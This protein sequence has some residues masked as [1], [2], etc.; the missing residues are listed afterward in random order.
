MKKFNLKFYSI[1]PFLLLSV[2]TGYS[3]VAQKLVQTK[4][5]IALDSI[6]L[7]GIWRSSWPM[8]VNI[9]NANGSLTGNRVVNTTGYTL[10]IGG[11]LQNFFYSSI[12]GNTGTINQ[13]GATIGIETN[14][15]AP[16]TA[17]S[18]FSASA[19]QFSHYG[20]SAKGGSTLIG[21]S[22]SVSPNN[23]VNYFLLDSNVVRMVADSLKFTAPANIG[24]VSILS[25][26]NVGIGTKVPVSALDV[27]MS[28][29]GDQLVGFFGNNNSSAYK[30]YLN[31]SAGDNTD[32]TSATFSLYNQ[33]N[34]MFSFQ[35][36]NNRTAIGASEGLKFDYLGNLTARGSLT[37]PKATLNIN[38]VVSSSALL[39][40]GTTFTGGTA[41][42][43]KPSL[44][45]EPAGASSTNWNTS[46][47]QVGINAASG[48]TG[49]I[50]WGGV[51]GSNVFKVD[52]TGKT[53][54]GNSSAYNVPNIYG[55]TAQSGLSIISDEVH[56]IS[57]S[58]GIWK[59]KY[60]G[61][62]PHFL[63]K[64]D[65][66]LEW[67][68]INTNGGGDLF[69]S[70]NSAGTLLVGTSANN[71]LGTV[72]AAKLAVSSS[73]FWCSGTGSPEG[74]ITAN[75]GSLY[76]RTDGSAGTS[77]Y[78]KESGTGNTGWVAK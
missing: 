31:I 46:G 26:G 69:L 17:N 54:F 73:V 52:Y 57:N 36:G 76:S 44:L 48:F 12:N 7:G 35:Y 41:T 4:Q 2:L 78:V 15:A 66:Q 27:R 39:L 19:S 62:I 67:S 16:N 40:S 68:N 10:T 13:S 59:I 47:T 49:D 75:I 8:S 56:G 30:S 38:N 28:T 11:G 77:L 23:A 34:G 1:L 50:L 55:G 60:S 37:T 3:Q 18:L 33:G 25:N 72:V 65:A 64:S 53:F 42:T 24:S 61:G 45:I 70:R 29:T 63:L 6:R 71:S 9:Y 14:L 5:L 51:N 32:G 43:T 21:S 22:G 74:V 58:V 20:I